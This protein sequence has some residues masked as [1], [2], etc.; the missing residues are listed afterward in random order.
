[1]SSESGYSTAQNLATVR[2]VSPE[3]RR[4]AVRQA[5]MLATDAEDL[6]Q[7]LNMLGLDPV[8]GLQ[9]RAA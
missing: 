7:L 2:R 4:R 1:M 3:G 5:A 6:R 9:K 8:E